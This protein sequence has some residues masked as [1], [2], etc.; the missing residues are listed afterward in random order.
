MSSFTRNIQ[1]ALKR[2]KFY[3]GRGS[4]L[5]VKNPR[6]KTLLARKKRE[7]RN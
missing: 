7:E 5:G 3:R 6:D 1:R 2:G 4:K